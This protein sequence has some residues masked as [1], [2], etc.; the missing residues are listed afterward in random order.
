MLVPADTV[1][2]VKIQIPPIATLT[3]AV[4]KIMEAKTK[5][6][7]LKNARG[8]PDLAHGM[9]KQT[10][11][12]DH[13]PEKSG[14]VYTAWKKRSWSFRQKGDKKKRSRRGSRGNLSKIT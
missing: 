8:S 9:Y 14:T 5:K 2:F 6:K 11:P 12:K 1:R 13:M 10:N 4:Q 3:Y 7:K